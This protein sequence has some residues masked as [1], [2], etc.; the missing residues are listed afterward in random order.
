MSSPN[1]AFFFLPFFLP[2]A[3]EVRSLSPQSA[4]VLACFILGELIFI[5]AS[6][7]HVLPDLPDLDERFLGVDCFCCSA[8]SRETISPFVPV[9]LILSFLHSFAS[10]FLS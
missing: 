1:I 7:F 4:I 9:A 10:C 8:I 2:F 3:P 5:C 6:D